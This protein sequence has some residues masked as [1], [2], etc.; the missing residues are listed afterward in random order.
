M[1]C[2]LLRRWSTRL[3]RTTMTS[4]WTDWSIATFRWGT[5]YKRLK[6]VQPW[7]QQVGYLIVDHEETPEL[8]QVVFKTLRTLD[9]LGNH[10]IHSQDKHW[11][12]CIPKEIPYTIAA[13]KYKKKEFEGSAQVDRLHNELIF[14]WK[15][16]HIKNNI[17]K[18]FRQPWTSRRPT[19]STATCTT[20]GASI[21]LTHFLL[22]SRL[23]IMISLRSTNFDQNICPG[24][25]LPERFPGLWR[26]CFEKAKNIFCWV[27]QNED[28]IL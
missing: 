11:D 13:E 19:R 15:N 28:A 7:S 1:K 10:H 5:D 9:K 22:I 16:F 20:Q 17:S 12:E 23:F 3:E 2:R 24:A 14:M 6:I 27:G 21:M 8:L 4:S 25:F 18:L 26:K